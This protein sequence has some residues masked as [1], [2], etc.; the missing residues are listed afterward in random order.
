MDCIWNFIVQCFGEIKANVR[1]RSAEIDSVQTLR[2]V[3]S[4]E[5]R[6]I[7]PANVAAHAAHCHYPVPGLP[8]NP[9]Q[10]RNI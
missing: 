4:E 10:W 6:Q 9:Y 7:P 3:L 2:R 1:S 5:T 8:Y